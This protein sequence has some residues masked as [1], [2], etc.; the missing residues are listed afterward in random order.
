MFY[1]AFKLIFHL[2]SC[3]HMLSLL[4]QLHTAR[5]AD[6]E[7]TVKEFSAKLSLVPLPPPGQLHVVRKNFSF[8]I[9]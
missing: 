3:L 8:S 1:F 9:R 2:A 7:E 4:V 6:F 5:Q